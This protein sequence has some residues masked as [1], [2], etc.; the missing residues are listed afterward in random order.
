MPGN[1]MKGYWVI[2]VQS[3]EIDGADISKGTMKYHASIRPIISN[4]WRRATEKEVAD[5]K[6]FK[7]K[8]YNLNNV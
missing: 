1:D 6:C 7:G 2:C 8:F 3:Y 5:M 4:K